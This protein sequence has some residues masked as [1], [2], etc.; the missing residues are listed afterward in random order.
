MI[1]QGINKEI[2]EWDYKK[3][4]F[5]RH[6]IMCYLS[7]DKKEG[8]RQNTSY[9]QF[10]QANFKTEEI[11]LVKRMFKMLHYLP[12]VH[13]YFKFYPTRRLLLE[14]GSLLTNKVAEMNF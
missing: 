2:K 8:Q 11:K 1:V 12:E 14:E 6:R 5:I 13:E 7:E 3:E 4:K 10:N 9:Y